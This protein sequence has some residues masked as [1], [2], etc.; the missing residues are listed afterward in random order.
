VKQNNIV[1]AMDLL[2]VYSEMLT[3]NHPTAKSDDAKIMLAAQQE[4]SELQ[5][6]VDV[7]K[8]F[9]DDNEVKAWSDVHSLIHG[10]ESADESIIAVISSI[11]D[12]V[13]YKV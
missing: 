3:V 12:I 10:E 4:L 6:L 7:V 11:C 5:R 9:I 2:R 13:G 8:G 1:I